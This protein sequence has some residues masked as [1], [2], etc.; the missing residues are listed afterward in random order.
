MLGPVSTGM[1]DH[2]HVQLPVH[3]IYLDLTNH[4]GQLSLAIPQWVGTM[5]TSQRAVVLCGWGVKA[6]MARVWWQVNP[7]ETSSYLSAIEVKLCDPCL[8]YL[9]P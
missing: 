7:C 5:S 9:C 4:P 6:G 1:G 3:E 2:V 8:L